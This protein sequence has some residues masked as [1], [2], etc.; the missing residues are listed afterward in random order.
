MTIIMS[1]D[2]DNNNTTQKQSLQVLWQQ[3]KK[4]K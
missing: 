1:I 4:S 2:S 3:S